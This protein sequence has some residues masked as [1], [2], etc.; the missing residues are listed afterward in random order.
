VSTTTRPP[1]N[2]NRVVVDRR[3]DERRRAVRRSHSRRRRVL[4]GLCGAVTLLVA[5]AWP[6]LHSHLFAADAVVVTGN[7]HTPTAEI[8]EAAGLSTHPPLLDVHGGAAAK[9]VEALPWVAS[10]TVSVHWPDGVSVVVTERTAVAVVADGTGWAELDRTGRVLATLRAAPD[11]LPHLVNIRRPG[12]PGSTLH[13]ARPLLTIASQLPPAFK[14]EVLAVAPA[15]GGGVDLALSGDL[16]VVF[17]APTQL[18]SKFEDIASLLAG[19][20]LVPGAI[21]DVSVPDSPVVANDGSAKS[22]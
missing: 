10:A 20:P 21:I 19:A 4:V 8:L 2:A 22:S 15:P 7:R 9:A 14:G 18:P 17:G 6:L 13:A 11:G 3:L 5:G 1:R 12:A 16:G